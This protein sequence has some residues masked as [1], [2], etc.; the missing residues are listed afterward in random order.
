MRFLKPAFSTFRGLLLAMKISNQ[1]LEIGVGGDALKFFLGHGL[2][3]DPGIVRQIPKLGIEPFPQVVCGV[4]ERPSQ[5]QRQLCESFCNGF[6]QG[7]T[8]CGSTHE[9]LLLGA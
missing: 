1:R 7:T 4:V 3:N 9:L 6:I 8:E 5:V 2:Q